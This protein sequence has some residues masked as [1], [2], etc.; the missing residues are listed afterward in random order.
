MVEPERLLEQSRRDLGQRRADRDVSRTAE[1]VNAVRIRAEA[2]LDRAA[3]HAVAHHAAD[4]RALD[5][6]IAG[7]HRADQCRRDELA[8]LEILGAAHD[9]D[10]PVVAADVDLGEPEGVGVRMALDV[11]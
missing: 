3:Q 9:L 5:P 10:R 2:Q 11:D 7:Q 1:D 4:L 6:P 8:N